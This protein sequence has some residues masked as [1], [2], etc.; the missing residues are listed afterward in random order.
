M[1]KTAIVILAVFLCSKLFGYAGK[2]TEVTGPTQITR[3]KNRIEG[4]V[5]VGI[6]MNDIL[7]T[8]KGKAGITF[9]D[10]T[11]VMCT[12]F[13]K[14]TIDEFVYDPSSGKGKLAM[15]ATLGTVRYASG[16]IAKNSR[17]DIKVKTPTA[18]VSVRGTDF[19]MTVDELGRS[20]IILLPSLPTNGPS[21]VGSITVANAA[22]IVT[23]TKAFQATYVS[24]VGD[25]PSAPVI[26]NFTD[27][28][29]VNSALLLDTPKAVTQAVK[30]IKKETKDTEKE[31]IDEKKEEVKAVVQSEPVKE[32]EVVQAPPVQ[33]EVKQEEPKTTIEVIST[34]VVPV[35]TVNNGFT[36]DGVN[37]ILT[38]N[39]MK[40]TIVYKVK[41]DTN[42]TFNITTIE[43]TTSYPLNFGDKLRVN[44]IQK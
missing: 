21:V 18:S 12:E 23:M 4:K 38:V 35:A 5:D 8:L 10:G 29:N 39:S 28:S 31:E 41:A 33:V 17:E 37:A 32:K 7:E 34:V 1:N 40:G 3:S 42:A 22:G 6:E 13:S 14:L 25:R 19:A 27:E 2:L 36:T 15:K 9:E 11:K 16:L 26:L 20:L 43:G 30:E 24:T 44:I